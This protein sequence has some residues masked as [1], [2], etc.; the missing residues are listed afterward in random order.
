MSRAV[1]TEV[2]PEATKMA[3]RPA[4]D[5]MRAI[6]VYLVV[7]FHAGLAALPGGYIGVDVFFVLSG[8]L[9]TRIILS[10][11]AGGS[12][13][14]ATFYNRRIRRLLP[15][16][17]LVLVIV[18]LTWLLIA[19]PVTRESV[20]ADIRSAALYYSNWHFAAESV[21]YF[22]QSVDSSPVLHFWSLSVEEQFYVFWP[23]LMLLL[24]RVGRGDARRAALAVGLAAALLAVLSAAA[25]V[26]TVQAGNL[27]LAYYGTHTRIYQLLA[28]AV[29]AV[30]VQ[31]RQWDTVGWVMRIAPIAQAVALAALLF[32]AL[33]Y[34]QLDP[35]IRGLYAA[36]AT[37]IVLLTLEAGP[38]AAV[39]RLLS[40]GVLVKLGMISYGIYLWHYPVTVV[41]KKF[42]DLPPF[43]LTALVAIL[44]TAL[45][46]L[47]NDLVE[48]PIR[49]SRS[50][51]RRNRAVIVT[52]L[53]ASLAV[54]LVLAPMVL[55]SD[56]PIAIEAKAA[57]GVDVLD[58]AARRS[59]VGFDAKVGAS[60]P[61]GAPGSGAM[62][63]DSSC[64]S[65]VMADCMITS[66]DGKKV[67]LLG[68]SHAMMLV[69][70][71][72][73]IG[74]RSGLNIA[75]AAKTGCP[76]QRGLVFGKSDHDAC[77]QARAVWYSKVLN[78][79]DPDV[80]LAVGRATDQ[81]IGSSYFVQSDDPAVV[82]ADQSELLL[83]ATRL[84]LDDLRKEGR[85][86]V[87]FEPV[88][89]AEQH[90]GECVSGAE[91]ADECTFLAAPAS[92]AELGY[93]DFAKTIPGV[94][95]LDLDPVVCPRLPICDAVLGNTLVRI[96]HDHITARW[97]AAIA[98]E[99]E[100]ALHAAGAW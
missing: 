61:S 22:A 31:S 43:L 6:A 80:V 5:G 36:V 94:A 59:L 45:A 41:V 75:L 42:A 78:T 93:R 30:G 2:S 33:E 57:G 40:V 35:A 90:Q 48:L 65:G 20:A 17:L 92:T 28:G 69:P 24:W 47:S 85:V 79:F 53:V 27:D 87:L 3:Y 62:P 83:A 56:R 9:V 4:L 63:A 58:P 16:A 50:L 97:S 74:E 51:A 7:A 32:L 19:A 1:A 67:L 84:G 38:T 88:P 98:D 37:I 60:V 12:F 54:G 11:L 81:P 73:I 72:R 55:A 34:T 18:A 100:V 39:A 10:D 86:I 29:L 26:L 52:G 89:V 8:Y 49:R 82:G 76:W 23:A 71:L 77:R 15:A 96:D 66:G 95:D 64:V 46:A 44:A 99:L 25:L 70:A 21:D 91:F 14:I 13:S 68:D